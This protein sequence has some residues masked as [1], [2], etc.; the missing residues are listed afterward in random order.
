MKS[1]KKPTRKAVDKTITFNAKWNGI[2]LLITYTKNYYKAA[3]ISHI[4]VK[5]PEPLPITETGFRSMWLH[6]EELSSTTPV[7]YLLEFLNLESQTRQ[8]KKYIAAQ[9]LKA[10]Q[11]NQLELF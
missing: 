10:K 11:S 9:K 7:A 1:H 4:T 6:E 8:W 2:P 3:G 5:A